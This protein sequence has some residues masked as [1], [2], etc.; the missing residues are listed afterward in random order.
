MRKFNFRIA[1]LL[2]GID[3]PSIMQYLDIYFIL[4]TDF[5]GAWMPLT[6]LNVPNKDVVSI[7][8][9]K[10]PNNLTI[11]AHFAA[12]NLAIHEE[13]GGRSVQIS[14]DASR[15]LHPDGSLLKIVSTKLK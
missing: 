7:I 10:I 6:G 1:K 15:A 8:F 4:T 9:S 14:S 2:S 3:V 11:R 13:S 5:H 12:R